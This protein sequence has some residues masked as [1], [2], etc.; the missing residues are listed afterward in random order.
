MNI[1][2]KHM[3]IHLMH[4]KNIIVFSAKTKAREVPAISA[5]P[6]YP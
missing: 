1:D 2:R 5:L 6:M 4:D 3:T